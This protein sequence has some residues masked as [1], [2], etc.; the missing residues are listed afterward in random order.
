MNQVA[1]FSSQHQL[2]ELALRRPTPTP[3]SD[4]PKTALFLPSKD[5]RGYGS[6]GNEA[7]VVAL[8]ALPC[9]RVELWI[10]H[11]LAIR[12]KPGGRF[13]AP[14]NLI[15]FDVT[16]SELKANMRGTRRCIFCTK[17]EKFWA[18]T[19]TDDF[20]AASYTPG[21]TWKFGFA[22]ILCIGETKAPLVP[23]YIPGPSLWGLHLLLLPI[24][25]K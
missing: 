18:G 4:L 19:E 1:S 14:K 15:L 9:P 7:T 8:M 25:V 10:R 12:G 5:R 2:R 17:A 24:M 23:L 22:S 3:E 13:V 21:N 16:P 20:L 6:D 11:S